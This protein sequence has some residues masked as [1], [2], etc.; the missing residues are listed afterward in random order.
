MGPNP[1]LS[2][3]EIASNNHIFL[4]QH[5][6]ISTSPAFYFYYGAIFFVIL[7]F[8]LF[9]WISWGWNQDG[10]IKD[11]FRVALFLHVKT[12]LDARPLLWKCVSFVSSFSCESN[13]FSYKKCCTGT[14]FETEAKGSK[15]NSEMAYWRLNERMRPHAKHDGNGSENVAEQKT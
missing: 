10:R 14:R 12:S 5:C 9:F 8:C 2:P 1:S 6:E 7:D 4:E 3:F 15:D 13:S 11:H